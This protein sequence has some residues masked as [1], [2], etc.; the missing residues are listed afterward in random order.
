MTSLVERPLVLPV[1]PVLERA[2]PKRE[3]GDLIVVVAFES[4]VLFDEFGVEFV[5]REQREQVRFAV[6]VA[7]VALRVAEVGDERLIL[8]P[9]GFR[10]LRGVDEEVFSPTE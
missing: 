7:R 1:L 8:L 10:G 9:E 6:A 3:V 4:E 2:I 5:A